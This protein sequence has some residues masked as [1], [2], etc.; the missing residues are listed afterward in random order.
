MSG[1]S[2]K[3]DS[4]PDGEI[5]IKFTG[6]RPGE[7]LFEELLIDSESEPT[8]HEK[9]LVA[10]DKHLRWDEIEILIQNLEEA[11]K[12]EDYEKIKEIFLKSVAGYK[13]DT[14]TIRA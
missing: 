11:S 1:K 12:D 4:N 2:I 8:V 5:E 7:K 10:K 13:P 3:D 6:L 9:I 14:Q